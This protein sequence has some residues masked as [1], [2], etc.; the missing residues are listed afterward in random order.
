MG[1]TT[2]R[3]GGLT[4]KQRRFVEA[5]A[6][7]AKGNATEAARLAGY[8]GNDVTLAAVGSENLRKPLIQAALQAMSA[9]VRT[10]A[11]W[12]ATQIQEFL[13][14]LAAGRVKE[15]HVTSTGIVYAKPK[16]SDRRAAAM[17]LAKMQ[18]LLVDKFDIRAADALD[19]KLRELEKVMPPDAYEA[20]LTALAGP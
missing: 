14:K 18:G 7:P 11:I 2:S 20:L 13:T 12:G 1:S 4:E 6:G 9:K 5:L 8:A 17:D 10:K 15:P 16:N 19:A 3:D